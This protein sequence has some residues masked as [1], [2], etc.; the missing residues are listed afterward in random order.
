MM[1]Q[2]AEPMCFLPAVPLHVNGAQTRRAGLRKN[3]LC[4]PVKY[5]NGKKAVGHAK[6]HARTA[7]FNLPVMA[8][9]KLPGKSARNV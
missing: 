7:P 1:G 3:I 9:L 4:L 2:A 6:M 5:A 8:G